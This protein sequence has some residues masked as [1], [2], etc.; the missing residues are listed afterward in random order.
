VDF[1]FVDGEH[2]KNYLLN[3]SEI[4][5]SV[6][7]PGGIIVWHD[8]TGWDGVTSGLDLFAKRNRHL[9]IVHLKG[10]TLAF[11]KYDAGK[12]DVKILSQEI[13]K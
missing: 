3:D 9:D 1:I 13:R 12:E 4:A 8:Y 10:T 5:L 2:S 6:V 11:T 7:K